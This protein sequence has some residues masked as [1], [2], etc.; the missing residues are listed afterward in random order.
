MHVTG[1]LFD[2][3]DKIGKISVKMCGVVAEREKRSWKD[4]I[5]FQEKS[6]Y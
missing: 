4:G 1:H 6:F 3:K 2:K 5:T